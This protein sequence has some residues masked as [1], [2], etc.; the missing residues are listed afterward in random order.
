MYAFRKPFTVASF[1]GLQF[2][3]ID[4]KIWLIASQICGYTLSKFIGIKVVSE[5]KKVNRFLSILFLILIAEISL[6]LFYMLPSP[7]NIALMFF[8]G[9]PL[10]MIWGIVFSYIEGRRHTELLGAVLSVSFIV[11]SGFV[12]SVG[13][14][15]MVNFGISEFAMPFVT[16]LTFLVPQ[17]FFLYILD[18]TP[19]PTKRDIEERTVR[20]PMNKRERV[21]FFKT[22]S[23]G[24][25]LIVISYSLMIIFREI[26]DNYILE[27]WKELGI[28]NNAKIFTQTEIPV[29]ILCL[30]IISMIM[31]FKNNFKAFC[32]ILYLVIIGLL[33]VGLSTLAYELG[34]ISAFVWIVAGGLGLYLQFIPYNAFI[35]ERLI[36]SFRY[37]SNVGFLIS[38]ADAFGYLSS[39]GVLVSKSLLADQRSWLSFFV[40]TSYAFFIVG[41]IVAVLTLIYFKRKY[42]SIVLNGS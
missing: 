18:C 40:N 10:G 35:F 12:K 37:V 13:M 2:L 33:V 38:L 19:N 15:M 42:K 7:Y 31:F 17:A 3:G 9:L 32:A 8:N 23:V 6:V 20:E 22:F 29:T 1:E 27:I 30:I 14:F 21:K 24:I 36:A 28:T 26:R 39:I 41:V 16:G 5:M 4:Y 34:Y 11:A 25:V